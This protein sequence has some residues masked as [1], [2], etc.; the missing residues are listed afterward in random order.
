[1]QFGD[2]LKL[3]GFTEREIQE[4]SEE[5]LGYIAKA[6]IVTHFYRAYRKHQRN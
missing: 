2:D 1:M 3:K 5:D 4:L 6:S